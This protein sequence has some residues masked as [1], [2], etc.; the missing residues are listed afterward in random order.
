MQSD[1]FSVSSPPAGRGKIA[2]R[3]VMP[4]PDYNK[5]QKLPEKHSEEDKTQV[6][7]ALLRAVLKEADLP[8]LPTQYELMP[9]QT[10]KKIEA[11]QAVELYLSSQLVQ[12][13]KAIEKLTQ[14]SVKEEEK[15]EH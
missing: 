1:F 8:E 5:V 6:M 12:V 4:P 2:G 15:D 3:R 13:R 14:E 11:L 9:F 7:E 10:A